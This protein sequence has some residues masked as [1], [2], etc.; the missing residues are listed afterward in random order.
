MADKIIKLRIDVKKLIRDWFFVGE[1]GT[2]ADITLLYNEKQDSYGCNG[3]LVQD[4]PKAIYEKD[5]SLKGP[6]LGNCIDWST[7]QP[8]IDSEALPPGAKAPEQTAAGTNA[9]PAQQ[10][11]P[12]P[13][14][15][16]PF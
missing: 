11:Q 16:L 5:K 8:Q 1:K 13:A 9:A 10:Q 12:P 7:R 2:Y 4:V 14:D 15:D 3:M 6:I